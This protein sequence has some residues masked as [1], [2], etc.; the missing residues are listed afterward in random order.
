MEAGAPV[1]GLL[2]PGTEGFDRFIARLPPQQQQLLRRSLSRDFQGNHVRDIVQAFI[3]PDRS[4][5]MAMRADDL[6]DHQRVRG[7]NGSGG[8]DFKPDKVDSAFAVKM[9][10]RLR[11]NDK[12]GIRFHI[13][14]AM[15]EQLQNAPGF[16][17]VIINIQP[18]ND[19]RMFL[20][21][22]EKEGIKQTSVI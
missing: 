10:S 15:L 22:K 12:E 8:I 14:P 13:D 9:D 11:G 18:M 3:R 19:L 16:M 21:L 17:P 7:T 6:A 2:L 20:G 5:D 1:T 4:R